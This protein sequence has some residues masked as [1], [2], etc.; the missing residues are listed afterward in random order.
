MHDDFKDVFTSGAGQVS[1]RSHCLLSYIT[2]KPSHGIFFLGG[3]GGELFSSYLGQFQLKDLSAM[4]MKLV[5][6]RIRCSITDQSL[7][8]L[9]RIAIEGPELSVVNFDEVLEIFKQ[10][11]EEL[12]FDLLF[13]YLIKEF[14]SEFPFI[15]IIKIQISW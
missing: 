9:M 6:T 7:G 14:C 3:R 15:I 2:Q 1:L 4:Y 12:C 11:I 10:K 8:R 13:F 5:K